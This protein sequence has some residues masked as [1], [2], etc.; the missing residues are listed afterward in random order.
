MSKNLSK[1]K[2]INLS[3]TQ[4]P[5]SEI[6]S[7]IP[8]DFGSKNQKSRDT[9]VR[10][11]AC[12]VYP[13]SAPDNWVSLVGECKTEAFISPL[14]DSDINPTGEPKKPHYHVLFMFEGK[15]SVEQVQSIFA[16]FGGV[17]CEKVNSIRGYARYLCHLDNPEKAQY[18]PEEV[19]CFGGADYISVIGLAID[20]YKAL[21]EMG[22]F[23]EKYNVFSFYVLARYSSKYRADWYR[24]L[25]DCG[26][27]Y[28]REYLNSRKWSIENG[29]MTLTDPETGE[30]I[31]L[32]ETL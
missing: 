28:M 25:C 3:D 5:S 13:D 19:K 7:A 11:F 29:Q 26:S 12:V 6:P 4:V 31:D 8:V 10:N 21:S 32:D 2:C 24:V 16:S 23:C 27:V 1:E 9:R 17:G 30:V 18:K 14:H 20:K 22:D 15:K